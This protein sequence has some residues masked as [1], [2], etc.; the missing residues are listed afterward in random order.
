MRYCTLVY[1]SSSLTFTL[2][3]LYLDVLSPYSLEDKE[4]L[5]FD[6]SLICI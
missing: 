3:I 2:D 5:M 4:H 6:I 1:T